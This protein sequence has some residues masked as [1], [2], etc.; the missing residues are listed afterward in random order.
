MDGVKICRLPTYVPI[1]GKAI[2]RIV[3]EVYFLIGVLLKIITGRI[4]RSPHVISFSPSI[5]AVLAGVLVRRSGGQH[6][7]VVHDIQSGLAAGL[8]MVGQPRFIQLMQFVERT[9]LNRADRIVVLSEKMKQTLQA[10]GV[11]RPIEVLPIWVDIEKIRPIASKGDNPF[12]VLYSG[13]LGRK[14]GLAQVLALAEIFLIERPE[15]RVIIRG[16]GS[17]LEMVTQQVRE[18]GLKN[19]ELHLLLP[20]EKLNEGLAEGDVH[21]VPQNSDAADFAVPSKIYGI[22][23]AGRPFV[24]TAVPGSTLWA[25]KEETGA[26]VCVRPN[27][28]QAFANAVMD[29]LDNPERRTEMGARGR[30]YVEEKA[31]LDVVLERYAQLL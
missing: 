15:V 2:S 27:D 10:Q 13:N 1:A 8:G 21:L 16:S 17:Q 4:S 19:V 3:S 18:R 7:A 31:A 6:L 30:K 22:M 11:R 26:L 23:A 9:V 25:L 28:S 12:V 24:C 5:L 29:L 20:L 14:Q